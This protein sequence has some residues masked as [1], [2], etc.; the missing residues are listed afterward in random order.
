MHE[1]IDRLQRELYDTLRAAERNR[2]KTG[3]FRAICYGGALLWFVGLIAMQF[4]VFSGG[5]VSL[6]YTPDPDATFFE[7]YKI[8]ILIVPLFTLIILGGFGLGVYVRKYTEAEHSSIRRI[9]RE[10]FP[11]AKLALQPSEV[12]ATMLRQSHFFG[13]VNNV[14]GYSC[15]IVVFEGDGRRITF[16]DMAL[17]RTGGGGLPGHTALGGLFIAIRT[18]LRGVFAAR[19]ENM[20]STFRGM[21]ANAR[22]EKKIDGSVVVL[23]DRLESRLDY[24][25]RNIQALK[26]VNGNR[27]VS[28]EDPEFERHFAVYSTD[29]IT[30][31]YVLTP[32]MMMRMTE[33]RE[34]YGRDIMLSFSGHDFYFAVEMPEGF[35]TLGSS[36]LTSGEAL[37][38]LYDNMVAARGILD[39]LKI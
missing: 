34:K 23:P 31:R 16:R 33:L 18:A 32:A 15:G 4:L 24:L 37:K 8:Y 30:A 25:A 29:E 7:R 14:A 6:F 39:D 36:S 12:S 38:D 13:G 1:K 20:T 27:L 35:L 3:V 9:M 10:M 28:L 26:S 2:R 22:L 5:D 21:F 11:D 17:N 19:V